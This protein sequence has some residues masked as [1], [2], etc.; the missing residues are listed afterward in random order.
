MTD[1]PC[2]GLNY[3]IG[4]PMLEYK[5]CKRRIIINAV[6]PAIVPPAVHVFRVS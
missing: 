5:A 6:K 4:R 3:N 1:S 2:F